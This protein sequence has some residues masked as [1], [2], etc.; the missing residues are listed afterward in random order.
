MKAILYDK[1]NRTEHWISSQSAGQSPG[2]FGKFGKG[3]GLVCYCW[4]FRNPAN[5]PV[6]VGS[7]SPALVNVLSF[8]GFLYIP[9]G[10]LGFLPS[11]VFDWLSGGDV[12]EH[13][14][15]WFRVFSNFPGKVGLMDSGPPRWSNITCSSLTVPWD[16]P[17]EI[18]QTVPT[19]L[20]S[21]L[22]NWSK[23]LMDNTLLFI[24]LQFF[25]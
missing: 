13:L 8:T 16:E 5:S 14:D 21:S 11:K 15:G 25:T 19:F 1:K 24:F 22:L 10:R 20:V 9:G 4:W 2:K 23:H 17:K 3:K 7:L 12:S 6:E 18:W